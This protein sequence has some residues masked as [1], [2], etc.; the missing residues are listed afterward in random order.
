M[1]TNYKIVRKFNL[2]DEWLDNTV[3]EHHYI[4][5]ITAY[6]QNIKNVF[7]FNN[8]YT[9]YDLILISLEPI[10][11]I[12]IKEDKSISY[13]KLLR[14]RYIKKKAEKDIIVDYLETSIIIK[15]NKDYYFDNQ[16]NKIVVGWHGSY[17]PPYDMDGYPIINEQYY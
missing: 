3:V 15:K 6:E 13:L 10:I 5:I 12:Q 2:T 11:Y 14:K 9:N 1:N 7:S 8:N 4:S 17:S 16:L